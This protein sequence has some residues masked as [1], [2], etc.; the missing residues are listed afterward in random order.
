MANEE[1]VAVLRQGSWAWNEWRNQNPGAWIDLRYTNFNSADLRYANLR[2]A[3]LTEADLSSADL[4]GADLFNVDLSNANLDHANLRSAD[5]S[6]A[7]LWRATFHYANL[8]GA[9]F[10]KA[11]LK[12]ANLSRASWLT[13][14]QL[15]QAYLCET[16]LP[17]GFSVNRNRDC[18]H[19]VQ[20]SN[21]PY[22]LSDF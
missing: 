15:S 4:S 20:Q 14:A 16:K 8:E 18:W 10:W 3:Y 11:S 6:N 7:N 13:T 12:G 21:E 9:T 5:L 22:T 19:Y 1:Q 2:N 17:E